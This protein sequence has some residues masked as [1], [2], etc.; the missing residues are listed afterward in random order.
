MNIWERDFV[1]MYNFVYIFMLKGNVIRFLN[2]ILQ[3]KS[4][5][6]VIRGNIFWEGY[7]N[8][9]RTWKRPGKATGKEKKRTITP[10]S[11]DLKRKKKLST[12]D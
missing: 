7:I 9:Q 8:V 3:V 1:C 6:V 5:V 11:A 10:T 12:L 4:E 2:I